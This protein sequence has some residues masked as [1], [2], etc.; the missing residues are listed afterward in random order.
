MSEK[1]KA[2]IMFSGGLDSTLAAKL[3]R[4]QGIDLI[5]LHLTSPFC[6]CDN[7][8]QGCR[9]ASVVMAEQLGIE[10]ITR[11]KGED[12]YRILKNPRYGY[13]SGINPCIDCR[14]Y[15]FFL[16]REE[17]EKRG[18]RFIVTGEVLGQRPMSQRRQTLE[19]IEKK[20]GL[21][22][23]IVRPLSAKHFPPTLPEVAGW[24]DRGKLLD[25]SGRSRKEQIRLAEKY[26]LRDYPCP[27]GGCL[28]TDRGFAKRVRDLFAHSEE[29]TTTDF[30]ILKLGRHFRLPSGEKLI[31]S[32]N[33]SE[34][35]RLEA[36]G[37]GRLTLVV[38]QDA[39]GPVV[40]IDNLNSRIPE[41]ELTLAFRR[42]SKMKEGDLLLQ[43]HHPGGEEKIL[44]IEDKPTGDSLSLD[45]YHIR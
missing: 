1:M 32:R 29:V 39:P 27:A 25:I 10:M 28:L 11:A 15:G 19:L 38:S 18:A 42:Y 16:A 35:R 13:G 44:R 3:M 14:I 30:N 40:A 45:E 22:G 34:N 26:S 43:F 37:K 36:M 4:D 24:V 23:L 41:K 17:M 7:S 9:A 8:R 5:A 2:I 12:Y 21:E 20:S 33:E 6:S 31:I